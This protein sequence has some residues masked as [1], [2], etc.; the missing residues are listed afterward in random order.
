MFFPLLDKNPLKVIRFQAVTLTLIVINV[1]AFL[2]TNYMLGDQ[3]RLNLFMSLGMVP[4]AVSGKAVLADELHLIPVLLTPITSIFL[5]GGWMHLIGNMAFLWVFADNVEDSFGHVPFLLFYLVCGLVAALAHLMLDPASQMPLIGASGAISGI[6]ASY[7]LLF[8]R[9][10]V[11]SLFGFVPLQMSAMWLLGLWLVFNAVSF[12]F[13]P[14]GG[15]VAWVTHLAGFVA[16]FMIT[17]PMRNRIRV[18]LARGA[19]LQ[20]QRELARQ[21][22]AEARSSTHGERQA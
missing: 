16:G 4:A 12:L 13:A 20:R 9:S 14:N 6:I 5:H 3:E 10:Q 11:I 21:A 19:A 22:G 1:L 2:Y 7:L 17:W 8:P 18:R 15:G